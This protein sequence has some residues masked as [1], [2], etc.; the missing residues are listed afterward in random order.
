MRQEVLYEQSKTKK[1]R[2]RRVTGNACEQGFRYP[3]GGLVYVNIAVFQPIL[4]RGFN[5]RCGGQ[6]FCQSDNA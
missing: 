3:D 6:H 4:G 2:H 1:R 5:C